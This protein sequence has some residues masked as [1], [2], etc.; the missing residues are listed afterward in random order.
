MAPARRE[1]P[2]YPELCVMVCIQGGLPFCSY[3]AMVIGVTKKFVAQ[4][5]FL[6][7]ESASNPVED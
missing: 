1:A 5:C 2:S 7:A 3:V 4:E 6:A